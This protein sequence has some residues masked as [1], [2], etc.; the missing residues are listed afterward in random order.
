MIIR[1]TTAACLVALL[2]LSACDDAAS[3]APADSMTGTDVAGDTDAEASDTA[4]T[5]DTAAG[6]DAAATT[7]T[8]AATDSGIGDAG[9]DAASQTDAT[10]PVDGAMDVGGDA[11]PDTTSEQYK[12]SDNGICATGKFCK[13]EPGFCQM[14]GT[15]T[16]KP[17]QGCPEIYSPICGCDGKD[18]S[19]ACEA[20][21]A[22][23]SVANTGT[24]A[25][26]TGCTDNSECS[27]GKFC[28]KPQG[29]CGDVGKCVAFPDFCGRIL[30]EVC[31]CDG[32][33]WP[34]PCVAA[35][36]GVNVAS[37]GACGVSLQLYTTCGDPVCSG[38]KDK[39]L[40]LCTKN[41][42]PGSGCGT[43]GEQCDPKDGCNQLYVCADKDPKQAGGCPISKAQWK[44]DLH[45]VDAQEA[46]ALAD[47]L[48]AV[49]L[50]T[51]RYKAQGPAAPK[52]LGFVIEDDPHSPAVD[53]E[54]DMVDLYGYLSMAV[55]TLQRQEQRID[56]LEAELQVLRRGTQRG[57]ARRSHSGAPGPQAMP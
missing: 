23:V 57:K 11:A 8:G 2:G 43:Q 19:N 46:A 27:A 37:K 5:T 12:C 6:T 34:S 25:N 17:T 36:Q 13:R 3:P 20:E 31:G 51:Y 16:P 35:L 55:A 39:G 4:A 54:R 14:L 24:C 42:Q 9:S 21:A 40:P 18:Y 38:W 7:D 10:D 47:R 22:G 45:Y 48:L 29:Q 53:P 26:P 30:D 1:T 41:Q 49:K 33:T 28:S 15:C 44:R 52:R 56:A 50:A 32:K